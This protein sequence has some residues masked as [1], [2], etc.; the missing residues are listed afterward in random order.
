M[1]DLT[2]KR[3]KELE[4]L[5]TEDTKYCTICKEVKPLFEFS[6]QPRGR[7]FAN[8]YCLDCKSKRDKETHVLRNFGITLKDYDKLLEKQDNCCAICKSKTPGVE[9]GLL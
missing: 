6:V 5:E 2:K 9:D 8:T 1:A 4:A 7:K 3:R